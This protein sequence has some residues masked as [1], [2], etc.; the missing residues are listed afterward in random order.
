[1][2]REEISTAANLSTDLDRLDKAHHAIVIGEKLTL[3]LGEHLEIQLSA[4]ATN[5][6]RERIKL[7]LQSQQAAVQAKLRELGVE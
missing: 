4:A 1:M 5:D 2:L 7:D 6:M 3:S